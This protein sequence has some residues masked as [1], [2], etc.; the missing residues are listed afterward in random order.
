MIKLSLTTSLSIN[1]IFHIVLSWKSLQKYFWN[2]NLINLLQASWL[3]LPNIH[4]DRRKINL[5]SKVFG[6]RK[7][8][9]TPLKIS[10]T[11]LL[12]LQC[13]YKN[14]FLGFIFCSL[15]AGDT[16]NL[17]D[18][19]LN[20]VLRLTDDRSGRNIE[21]IDSLHFQHLHTYYLISRSNLD[22]INLTLL[23]ISLCFVV[24]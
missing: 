11:P 4:R 7:Q 14:L 20:W 18:W 23:L 15:Y 2:T 12:S 1:F 9:A 10:I 13:N 3:G 22:N 19:K 16:H 21:P 5:H 24:V 6:C 8:L 17:A